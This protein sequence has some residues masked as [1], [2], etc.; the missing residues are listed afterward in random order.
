MRVTTAQVSTQSSITEVLEVERCSSA[1]RCPSA[2]V[3]ARIVCAVRGRPP[4]GPNNCGRCITSRTGRPSWRDAIAARMTCDHAEPLPPNAPPTNDERTCTMSGEMPKVPASVLRT[5]ATYCVESSIASRSPSQLASVACGSIG[6]WC[7]S[8]VVQAVSIRNAAAC[9]PASMSPRCV[10]GDESLTF[11]G[12]YS[13]R[14]SA[15]KS[16]RAAVRS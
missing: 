6:L 12:A 14:R 3:P 8:G 1:V 11:S 9:S 5:P 13:L 4:T 15:S 2:S 16:R 10:S 7:C